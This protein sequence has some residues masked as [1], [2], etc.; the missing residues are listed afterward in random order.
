MLWGLGVKGLGEHDNGRIQQMRTVHRCRKASRTWPTTEEEGF[1]LSLPLL[2]L[3][4]LLPP[5]D[6]PAGRSLPW[7]ASRSTY[8][9]MKLES[10]SSVMLA[11]PTRST[12]CR[13]GGF[14]VVV[15]VGGERSPQGLG[16][17]GR[18]WNATG[19]QSILTSKPAS[20]DDSRSHILRSHPAASLLCCVC[21][22][23]LA[24]SILSLG[25]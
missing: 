17:A 15:G 9:T 6:G 7:S 16:L 10:A 22:M 5:S 1:G 12:T 14:W 25:R 8:G 11:H 23:G 4:L 3:V 13:G 20:R 18:D 2:L 19:C 21:V 24:G